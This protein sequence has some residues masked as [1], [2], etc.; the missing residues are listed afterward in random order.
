M[1]CGVTVLNLVPSM[2]S[3]SIL[4]SLWLTS[5][6]LSFDVDGGDSDE[7]LI[8]RATNV[9]DCGETDGVYDD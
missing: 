9:D 8:G 3:S 6:A 5:T 1:V 7:V 2:P 4:W